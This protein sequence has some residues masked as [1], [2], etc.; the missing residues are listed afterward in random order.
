MNLFV[1]LNRSL[2]KQG[3]CGGQPLRPSGGLGRKSAGVSREVE[4][5]SGDVC[6]RTGWKG[7]EARP[8]LPGTAAGPRLRQE[9]SDK[10]H[11]GR[12]ADEGGGL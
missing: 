1:K 5:L 10:Q 8:A 6:I 2:A 4:A 12:R 3:P 7:Q 9:G 11:Q